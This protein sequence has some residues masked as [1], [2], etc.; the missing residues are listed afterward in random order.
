MCYKKL[1]EADK[2]LHIKYSAA[3]LL[4]LYL[5]FPIEVALV[6]TFFIGL[7]KECWDHYYGSGFCYYDMLGNVLGMFAVV[8]AIGLVNLF[9]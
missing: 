9:F 5:V 6:F 7:A 2:I 8:L 4:C 1:R 3:I